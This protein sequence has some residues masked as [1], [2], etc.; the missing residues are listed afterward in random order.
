MDF[1]SS[2]WR[3]FC[4]QVEP[5]WGTCFCVSG[6]VLLRWTACPCWGCSTRRW[7]L[8]S[9]QEEMSFGSWWSTPTQTASSA[10]VRFSPLRNISQVGTRSTGSGFHILW[11]L[12]FG[13]T[14]QFGQ[15]SFSHFFSLPEWRKS[16]DVS[17]VWY[18]VYKAVFYKN[19]QKY[20]QN[21]DFK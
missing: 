10:V 18:S 14:V 5:D 3:A 2:C 13:K 8:P 1:L 6:C 4:R 12:Q 7:W 11:T 20:G 16:W 21:S 15:K 17:R 9:K 19:G